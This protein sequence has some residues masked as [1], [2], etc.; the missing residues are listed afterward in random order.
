MNNSVKSLK[1][2]KKNVFFGKLNTFK[3]NDKKYTGTDYC[4]VSWGLT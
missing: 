1:S 4:T 3:N 2:F